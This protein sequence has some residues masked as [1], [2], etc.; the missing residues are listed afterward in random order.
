MTTPRH[1]DKGNRKIVLA[2]PRSGKVS[3]Y[4]NQRVL[5]ALSEVQ[6]DLTLYKGVRLL[7]VMEAVY[8]QGKKDGREEALDAVEHQLAGVAKEVK[9]L[10]PTKIGRPRKTS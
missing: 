8:A 10:R 4:S 1:S 3:I 5:N 2:L 9:K 6:A 7:Q